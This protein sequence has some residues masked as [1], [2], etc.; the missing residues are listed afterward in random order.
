[1]NHMMTS[2]RFRVGLGERFVAQTSE[3]GLQLKPY[4]DQWM[5]LANL[6]FAVLHSAMCLSPFVIV[7]R[8]LSSFGFNLI[9]FLNFTKTRAKLAANRRQH[10]VTGNI[11][12]VKSWQML[13]F[14][15]ASGAFVCFRSGV[16][17]VVEAG[18]EFG[19]RFD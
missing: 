19:D 12:E 2:C 11:C 16:R 3:T 8:R 5:V 14:T 6:F 13:L 15:L 17:L 9:A 18:L 10:R 1:M 7:C 4:Q